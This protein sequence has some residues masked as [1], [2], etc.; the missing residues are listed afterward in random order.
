MEMALLDLFCPKTLYL[1]ITN[2]NMYYNKIHALQI[3]END[4]FSIKKTKA[5]QWQY[6]IAGGDDN[7]LIFWRPASLFL[8]QVKINLSSL[9]KCAWRN[10]KYQ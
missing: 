7:R 10:T 2:V 3:N 5:R 8:P 9:S 6:L 1:T 4:S